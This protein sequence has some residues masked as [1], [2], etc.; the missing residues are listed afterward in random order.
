VGYGLRSHVKQT[1]QEEITRNLTQKAQLVANRIRSDRTHSLDLIASQEGLAGGARVTLIDTNGQV[2]ADS[3]VPANSLSKEG[4][5]P[6]FATALHGATG[7]EIST[8]NGARV[9]FVAVPVSGG[10]VRLAYPMS[11]FEGVSG[12]LNR[13]LSIGCAAAA[14]AGLMLSAAAA[15][16]LSR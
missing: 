1:L 13:R 7:V 6:E 2:V 12:E 5:R 14:L 10:A 16:V 11:D 4:S 8:R 3:E 15:K 9:M